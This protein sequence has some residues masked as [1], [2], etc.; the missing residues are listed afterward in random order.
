ML[1]DLDNELMMHRDAANKRRNKRAH[2]NVLASTDCT[3]MTKH[4]TK[5]SK[6]YGNENIS[7]FERSRTKK[8][9]GLRM[10]QLNFASPKLQSKSKRQTKRRAL[11]KLRPSSPPV[12]QSPL[13]PLDIG[14]TS[15]ASCS[16][17]KDGFMLL[18]SADTEATQAEGYNTPRCFLSRLSCVSAPPKPIPK[19]SGRYIHDD[20]GVLTGYAHAQSQSCPVST[21]DSVY[22]TSTSTTATPEHNETQHELEM[23][24]IVQKMIGMVDFAATSGVDDIAGQY[25][26]SDFHC[27][28]QHHLY[29]TS[30][31][32]TDTSTDVVQ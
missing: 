25:F 22:G 30:T 8:A 1:S 26:T 13:S 4:P 31:I 14:D 21:T 11:S 27:A 28:Y 20:G 16:G 18:L 23:A 5:R 15:T 10:S 24:D 3:P 12:F 17:N 19:P 32:Y 29:T 7:P 9:G 6:S 2:G